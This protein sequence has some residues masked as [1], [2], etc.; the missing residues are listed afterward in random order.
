MENN[1]TVK[2]DLRFMQLKHILEREQKS[3]IAYEEAVEIGDSLIH[4]FE[5]LADETEL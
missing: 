2:E 4:F 3:E 1:I 5:I